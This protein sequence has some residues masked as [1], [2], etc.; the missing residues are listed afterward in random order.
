MEILRHQHE[1][2]SVHRDTNL[3]NKSQIIKEK[4]VAEDI[5][6]TAAQLIVQCLENEGVEYIFGLPGE[7]NIRLIDA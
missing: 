5:T 4:I 2:K 6:L 7:E 1:A 3:E